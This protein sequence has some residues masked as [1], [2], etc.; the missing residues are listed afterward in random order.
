[1]EGGGAMSSGG[2][3]A[4]LT[5]LSGSRGGRRPKTGEELAQ[6]PSSTSKAMYGKQSASRIFV[7]ANIPKIGVVRSIL[8]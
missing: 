3:G 5:M 8:T 1:M 7:Y 2:K 6:E 4:Q